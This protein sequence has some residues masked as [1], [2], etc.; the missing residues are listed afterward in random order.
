MQDHRVSNDDDDHGV[1]GLRTFPGQHSQ[2][3]SALLKLKKCTIM[4]NSQYI[5]YLGS[6]P[7]VNAIS[8]IYLIIYLS[9]HDTLT[10]HCWCC[11][12]R[13]IP[14]K[15]LAIIKLLQVKRSVCCQMNNITPLSILA[16]TCN[17]YVKN[18][19]FLSK[20]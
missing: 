4:P 19:M 18:L 11:V 2:C 12:A 20:Y 3:L 5:F 9:S 8:I 7:L 15:Q 17:I 10:P 13:K 14:T 1:T 16:V 6:T